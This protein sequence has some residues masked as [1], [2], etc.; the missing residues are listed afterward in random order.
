[1]RFGTIAATLGLAGALAG[2]QS[3]LVSSPPSDSS[4][5]KL[6][7]SRGNADAETYA[8]YLSARFA[9]TE[10]NLPDA[11]KFYRESLD[12]DPTNSTLLALAFFYST[13]S[14]EVDDA[15]RL[16]ERVTKNNSDDRAARLTLAVAALKN[17][18]YAGARKNLSLS[19]KGPFT[20][21]TSAIIDAWAAAGTGD[22]AAAFADLKTMSGTNGADALTAFHS[23]LLN[24]FLGHPSEADAAYRDALLKGGASPRIVEAYGRFLERNG[25]TKEAQG[26]YAKLA[27]DPAL[28]PVVAARQA[29]MAA[30]K[31]PDPLV[32]RPQDGA[33]EALFGI[34]GSLTDQS[35]AD[36]SILYL[37]LALYLRPDLALGNVLLGDRL[38]ALQKYQDAIAVY[39]NIEKGSP[40]WRLASIQIAL[41][42]ARLEK[43][44]A[45]ITDLQKLT[46]AA[47]TDVDAW[48]ALGD[49]QRNVEHW[50][51][52]AAAYDQAIK[53]LGKPQQ[54]DWPLFYSRA[55]AEERSHRWS[56]AEPDLQLALK[57]S[58]DEPQ[59]LN[60]LGYSWVDQGRNIPQ[61]LGMLEKARQ[62]KPFDGYIVDSVG[63][64]YF[65]LG[66]FDD[67]AKT[68]EDAILLVP[69][70]PTINEHLGDAFWRVGKKI[71]ARFQWS[72]AL[73]FGPDTDQ[74]SMLEKK[75]KDGLAPG[76]AS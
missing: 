41:D 71:D 59:V 16:A 13:S 3:I 32:G 72:H 48:T 21:L 22:G 31:K 55:I 66:R 20:N 36:I 7:L 67:A 14:G 70:D 56:A 33:A 42:E 51:E 76:N 44:D 52:A 9:A 37:R 45:A 50:S 57:L 68:L 49:A 2:C 29:A 15:A 24:D 75:L 19:A 69:G 30:G 6:T 27:N 54:K 34:A 65:K 1:L 18:D 47:P 38:E 62:L 12:R 11:A 17:K 73:A 61:A 25:R 53:V 8:N 64:A 28:A 10:H 23:A 39:R 58:P 46:A 40:Y 60:Y 43:S 4:N 5:F 26:L 74:K 35:S 63:W